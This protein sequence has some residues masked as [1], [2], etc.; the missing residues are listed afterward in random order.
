MAIREFT[1]SAGTAWRVWS[2]TPRADRVVD[3]T[4]QPGDVA[5][6]DPHRFDPDHNGI[7]CESEIAG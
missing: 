1:D 6:P 4:D 5:D 3:R 7:G 2:T